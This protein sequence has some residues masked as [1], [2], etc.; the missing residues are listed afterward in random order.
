MRL[1]TFG[2][3]MPLIYGRG[4]SKQMLPRSSWKFWSRFS[5]RGFRGF[6]VSIPQ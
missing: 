5:P 4:C 3:R 6:M 1:R 2:A